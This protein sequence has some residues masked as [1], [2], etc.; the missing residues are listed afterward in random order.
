MKE[1]RKTNGVSSKSESEKR[2]EQFRNMTPEE[3]AAKR[4]EI[5][6]RL[7]KK[8][9]ELRAKQVNGTIT[10]QETRELGRREKILRHFEEAD[11]SQ[12]RVERPKPAL[13]NS[14]ARK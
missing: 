8:I 2:R 3:R 14:P 10:A 12:P 11:S 13:T 1:G 5:K 7:E 6:G 9:A 4:K